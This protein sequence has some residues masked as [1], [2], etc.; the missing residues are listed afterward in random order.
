MVSERAVDISQRRNYPHDAVLR[1][2]RSW[3]IVPQ[4]VQWELKE[5]PAEGSIGEVVRSQTS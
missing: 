4:E 1:N 5:Q 3:G 2:G